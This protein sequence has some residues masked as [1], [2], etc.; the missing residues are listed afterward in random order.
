MNYTLKVRSMGQIQDTDIKLGG[1]TVVCGEN[2]CGKTTL[3]DM[4]YREFYRDPKKDAAFRNAILIDTPFSVD[5]RSSPWSLSA[6]VRVEQLIRKPPVVRKDNELLQILAEVMHGE[7]QADRYHNP[8]YYSYELKQTLSLCQLSAGLKAFTIL[9]QLIRNG[10]LRASTLLI[11]DG[12]ETHLH[13]R[14]IVEYARIAVLIRK[15]LKTRIFITTHSPDM[16][17]ALKHI[18]AKEGADVQF[19]LAESQPDGYV[20]RSLGQDV[21]PIFKSVNTALDLIAKYGD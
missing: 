12:P 19:Y 7:I 13:P 15:R 20:Y 9:Y 6:A 8:T 2:G 4:L 21:G 14:W 5:H 16:V 1:I 18:G 11:L 10:C 17:S 3:S